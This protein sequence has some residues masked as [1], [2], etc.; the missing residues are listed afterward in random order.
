MDLEEVK[1]FAPRKYVTEIDNTARITR[2]AIYSLLADMYLW[3]ASDANVS[4]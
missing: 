3:R 2:N 4:A 1:E